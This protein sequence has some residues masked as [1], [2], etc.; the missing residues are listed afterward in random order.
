MNIEIYLARE[1]GF[2]VAKANAVVVP[3]LVQDKKH[4]LA[5]VAQSLH[6]VQRN[7]HVFER[8]HVHVADQQDLVRRV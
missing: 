7:L 8:R 2:E 1:R 3:R 6:K 5:A 4:L